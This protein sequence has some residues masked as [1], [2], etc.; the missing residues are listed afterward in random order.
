MNLLVRFTRFSCVLSPAVLRRTV[1]SWMSIGLLFTLMA[2]CASDP[3]AWQLPEPPR[4]SNGPSVLTHSYRMS[5]GDTVKIL[6][7][8][9][10]ELSIEEPVRP[11][12]KISVP[13]VGDIMAVGRTPQELATELEQKI[14]DYIK[15]PK[16]TVILTSLKGQAFLSR[17]RVTGSV[18]RN[19]SIPY[20]QGM[21]VLDAILEAGGVDVYADANETRLHRRIDGEMVS[22]DIHLEDILEGTDMTSNVM[23]MPGDIITVPERNF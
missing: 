17:V 18:Q 7:W 23:L 15:N 4:N 3:Q 11:D 8:R 12:G 16:V 19:L 9:N 5:V 13:L 20:H 22:Y 6:V 21:T 10:K 1:L 14:G 2:G